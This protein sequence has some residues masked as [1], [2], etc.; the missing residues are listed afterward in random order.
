MRTSASRASTATARTTAGCRCSSS[1]TARTGCQAHLDLPDLPDLLALPVHPARQA[2]L[3]PQELVAPLDRLV[4]LALL[5]PLAPLAH[6]DL[7]ARKAV[8]DRPDPLECLARLARR[9]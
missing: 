8:Q 4:L 5:D 9:R 1:A 6:Q 2:P 7:Q 3:D